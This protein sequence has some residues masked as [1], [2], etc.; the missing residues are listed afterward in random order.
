MGTFKPDLLIE[1]VKRLSQNLGPAMT[2][3]MPVSILSMAPALFLSYKGQ[4]QTFYL[5]LAGL[6]LFVVA[7]LTTVLIEVPIVKQIEAWTPGSLPAN[8][9]A[10]RDRWLS[11]HVVRIVSGIGGLALL[12]IAAIF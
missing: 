10:L 12:V 7:L 4:R 5:T 11:F 1:I 3:L 2:I 8:W 9:Q 6:A